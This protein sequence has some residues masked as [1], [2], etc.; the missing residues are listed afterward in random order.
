ME[1]IKQTYVL[2]NNK[3]QT[4]DKYNS[5]I[6][7]IKGK[8]FSGLWYEQSWNLFYNK[9][10]FNNGQEITEEYIKKQIEEGNQIIQ[11][12]HE[13]IQQLESE[14]ILN[15]TQKWLIKDL[16]KKDILTTKYHQNA[17]YIEA[18]KWWYKL[19]NKDRLHYRRTVLNIEN[20]LYWP[21]ITDIPSRQKKV[22]TMLHQLYETNKE[23]LTKEEES[24]WQTSVIEKFP[25][26]S[27]VNAIDKIQEKKVY[28]N[29]Q[30]IFE[31]IALLLEIEW[32]KKEDMIKIQIDSDIKTPK[33]PEEWKNDVYHIPWERKD[34]DVYDYFENKWIGQKFKIIKKT[35]WSSS[36]NISKENGIFKKNQISI[37]PA[38]NGKYDLT[39]NILPILYDHEISTHVNTWIGN[40]NNIYMRDPDRSDLEEGIALFNQKMAQNKDIQEVYETGIADIGMFLWENFD[41]YELKKLIEIYFKMTQE[42]SKDIGDRVKRIKMW[43]PVWSLWARRKDLTYWNSKEIIKELEK[44]TKTPEWIHQLNTYARAIYST[45]LWYNAIQN[46]NNVLDGIKNLEEMEP[47]FPIFAGKIIY[48]KLFNWKLDKEKMLENDLRRYIHTEKTITDKQKRLLVTILQLIKKHWEQ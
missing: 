19:S 30:H 13:T 7:K 39:N 22:V 25:T 18:E 46:I 35:L 43:V 23:R 41:E 21:P 4:I 34:K 8:L 17:I 20:Q 28:I 24:L 44:L 27:S 32:F 1:H 5:L 38:K 12:L 3:I 29:E 40:F 6:E 26:N 2:A 48:R 42:N 31:M 33:D 47:N 16:I 45:K 14:D 37:A 10:Y 36:I 11:Q 9:A 15:N